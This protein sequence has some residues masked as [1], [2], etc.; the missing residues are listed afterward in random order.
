M[1]RVMFSA[2]TAALEKGMRTYIDIVK[3]T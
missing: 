3:N 1:A 2:L